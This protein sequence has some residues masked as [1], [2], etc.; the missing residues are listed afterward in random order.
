MALAGGRFF[1]NRGDPVIGPRY[2][3]YTPVGSAS[4]LNDETM[5]WAPRTRVEFYEDFTGPQR[6]YMLRVPLFDNVAE[7]NEFVVTGTQT[8]RGSVMIPRAGTLTAVRL[9]AE[10]AL[11]AHGTNHITFTLTNN[12]QDGSGSTEML[13]TTT[14]ANTTDSDLAL[15]VGI[16]AETGRAFTVSGT[17]AS[18][19][20]AA[21]DLL[22]F[23]GT[24]AGTLANEVHGPTVQLTFATLP[25]TVT[26]RTTKTVGLIGVEPVADTASGEALLSLVTTAEA[27][28]VGFDWGD[29]NLIPANARP[30]FQ[31]RAKW[32]GSVAGVRWVMGLA[33]SYNA[34]FNSVVNNA[35]F[36]IDGANLDLQAEV[37]DSTTDDDDNDTTF[38]LV[39][40]TYYLFTIDMTN[41]GLI[42]FSVDD[43]CYLELAGAAFAAADVLQPVIW[44]QSDAG[45]A[46]TDKTLTVDY[47]R[48]SW[49]RAA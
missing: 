40:N 29:Q 21:G 12:G 46:S 20:V 49:D 39:A 47:V 26:P 11:T 25:D 41:T 18:L 14:G 33:D 27:Q 17:A 31:C 42:R 48:C 10:D 43:T 7:A 3:R 6:T 23:T 15:A 2:T 16:T 37:D 36:R 13:S 44:L 8:A 4:D 19:R 35:W 24:S 30:V 45:G 38:N 34:T 32:S 5:G 9:T 1:Y 22:T 28:V